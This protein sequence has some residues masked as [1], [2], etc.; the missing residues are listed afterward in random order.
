MVRKGQ[1][2]KNK[3]GSRRKDTR[4]YYPNWL[5]L[6]TENMRRFLTLARLLG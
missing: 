1:K 4:K 3:Y 5:F 6:E 2:P